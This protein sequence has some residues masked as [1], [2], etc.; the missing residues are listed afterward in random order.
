ME[1]IDEFLYDILNFDSNSSGGAGEFLLKSEK[2]IISFLKD[3]NRSEL[4]FP[5]LNSYYR[6]IIHRL[7]RRYNLVHRVEATSIFNETST[8]RRIYLAK[9]IG[10]NEELPIL[11]CSDWLPLKV[12]KSELIIL[13]EEK[14]KKKKPKSTAVITDEKPK[15][16][17]L[18][19]SSEQVNHQQPKEEASF[20]PQ[21]T[22]PTSLPSSTLESPMES[23]S[24]EEREA[25]YQ[26]ARDR[27][28]EGFTGDEDKEIS[29]VDNNYTNSNCD[30]QNQKH[31]ASYVPCTIESVPSSSPLS[32][33]AVSSA[34]SAAVPSSSAE[35]S[36]ESSNIIS[37]ASTP[38]HSVQL[39]PDAIPFDFIPVAPPQIP[40]IQID[41]IFTITSS[42]ST[43]ISREDLNNFIKQQ[44]NDHFFIIKTKNVPTNFCFI[45]TTAASKMNFKND[46]N[47]TIS[48]WKPDF[49]F[50]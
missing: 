30:E 42:T 40:N 35:F 13:N 37:S 47:W 23:L 2:A 29:M 31:T 36:A 28:F 8:L 39:N 16:K 24:F 17:I 20:P 5:G 41:H 6:R 1:K 46:K 21:L 10:F 4:E 3:V 34:K 14:L 45:L 22:F 26:A 7:G 38:T 11:K 15:F 44:Q 50:D 18:K 32:S 27:I 49:F 9:P 33:S 48:N 12:C 19:R 43:E 25:K